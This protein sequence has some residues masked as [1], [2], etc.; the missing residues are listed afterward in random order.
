MLKNR[1]NRQV[2]LCKKGKQFNYNLKKL[3]ERKRN[4]LLTPLTAFS[5]IDSGETIPTKKDF[6]PTGKRE[7]S[8]NRRQASNLPQPQAAL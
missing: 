3:K 1:K 6:Q 8:P 7:G 5:I 2:K 4:F